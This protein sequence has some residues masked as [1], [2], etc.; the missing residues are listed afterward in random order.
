MI[1]L[2]QKKFTEQEDKRAQGKAMI[3]DLKET[4][5]KNPKE[6]AESIIKSFKEQN[7]SKH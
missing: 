3:D 1:I 7:N 6:D 5:R 2:R 4:L